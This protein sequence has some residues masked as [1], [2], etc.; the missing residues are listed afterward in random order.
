MTENRSGGLDGR[1][2]TPRML[3]LDADADRR[4]ELENDLASRDLD[5]VGCNSPGAA[6]ARVRMERIDAVAVH[7]GE[8]VQDAVEICRHLSTNW[9]D[10]PV[11]VIARTGPLG[12]AVEIF[13]AGA[14][15]LLIGPLPQSAVVNSL[16]HAAQMGVFRKDKEQP[17][18]RRVTPLPEAPSP[19]EQVE[20]RLLLGVMLAA[21]GSK[22]RA[23]QVLGID[24]AALME[25]LVRFGVS[26]LAEREDESCS[27]PL[28]PPAPIRRAS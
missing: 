28:P 21:R 12:A 4:A 27:V 17:R 3:V 19:E 15:D 24:R 16:E 18:P 20:R 5:V 22:T 10:L 14:F 6:L 23:A 26:S 2:P 8:S 25:R 11:V 7:A 9:P 1:L 13:Q